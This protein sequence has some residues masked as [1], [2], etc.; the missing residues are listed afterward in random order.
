MI[1]AKSITMALLVQPEEEAPPSEEPSSTGLGEIVTLEVPMHHH[2]VQINGRGAGTLAFQGSLDGESWHTM[3][4]VHLEA[5]RS[6]HF[7]GSPARSEV[8]PTVFSHLR[9]VADGE[10]AGGPFEVLIASA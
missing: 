5:D 2:T 7:L 6:A 4:K 3:A 10:L 8:N 9:V 1:T